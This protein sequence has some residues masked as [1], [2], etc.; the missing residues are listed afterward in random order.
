MRRSWSFFGGG[1]RA[2]PGNLRA[3]AEHVTIAP[4]N[5][6]QRVDHA[7]RY[8]SGT[9][10][11]FEE[12]M[13]DPGRFSALVA[14]MGLKIALCSR[15]PARAG[16]R[17]SAASEVSRCAS[18]AARDPGAAGSRSVRHGRRSLAER[19]RAIK[20]RPSSICTEGPLQR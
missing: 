16:P 2:M 9:P 14:A 6:Q 19:R 20:W 15:P 3:F 8:L 5:F 13:G 7:A 10:V 4:D 17:G 12:C 1:H 11:G 18:P